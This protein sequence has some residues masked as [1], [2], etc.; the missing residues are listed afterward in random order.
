MCRSGRLSF[1]TPR[2]ARAQPCGP[3]TRRRRLSRRLL[4]GCAE[5][6]LGLSVD[7]HFIIRAG[8]DRGWQ[9]TGRPVTLRSPVKNLCQKVHDLLGSAALGIQV[10]VVDAETPAAAAAHSQRR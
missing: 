1:M 9:P 10:G 7:S 2:C 6:L 8:C 5:H 3:R 4:S